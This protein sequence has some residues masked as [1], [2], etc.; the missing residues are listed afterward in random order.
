MKQSGKFF[1][2][3][4]AGSEGTRK[5]DSTGRYVTLTLTD[6]HPHK[7]RGYNPYDTVAH[8]LDARKRDVWRNK[9]KRA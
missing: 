2:G 6:E 8:A 9:P 3:E 1:P 7:V 4:P 5:I